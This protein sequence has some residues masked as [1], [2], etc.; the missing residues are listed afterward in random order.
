[1]T[2]INMIGVLFLKVSASTLNAL[3]GSQKYQATLAFALFLAFEDW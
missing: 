2:N 1:M 3:A